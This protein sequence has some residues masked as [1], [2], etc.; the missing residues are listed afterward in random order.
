MTLVY[1]FI[2][3][4]VVVFGLSAVAALVWAVRTG[5]VRN[6]GA[7]ATSIFDEDEPVGLMTDGFPDG[8]RDRSRDRPPGGRDP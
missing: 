3:G 5:Q 4:S 6:F 8:G 2:F 1:V 7:G